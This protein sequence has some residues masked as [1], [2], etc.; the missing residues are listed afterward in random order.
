MLFL[1]VSEGTSMCP[2]DAPSIVLMAVK[3]C[4]KAVST[5]CAG[6]GKSPCFLRCAFLQL[7]GVDDAKSIFASVDGANLLE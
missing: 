2:K 4:S 1:K 5:L 6:H 3:T 7:F